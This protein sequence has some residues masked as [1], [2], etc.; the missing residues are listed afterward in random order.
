M[1]SINSTL[2]RFAGFAIGL[3]F[4]CVAAGLQADVDPSWGA[5]RL[6]P[7]HDGRYL[8]VEYVLEYVGERS[9]ENDYTIQVYDLERPLS[10]PRFVPLLD[11][12]PGDVKFS[13]DNSMIAVGNSHGPR[14]YDLVDFEPVLTLSSE[15]G[16]TQVEFSFI[17]FSPDS[18]YI[19]AFS[20]FWEHD[21]YVHVWKIETG[22]QVSRVDADRSQQ[23]IERPWLS[24]DWRQFFQWHGG[25]DRKSIIYEFDP[26]TGLSSAL[27]IIDARGEGQAAFSPDSSLFAMSRPGGEIELYE[28]VSWTLKN[29]ITIGDHSCDEQMSFGFSHSRSLLAITCRTDSRL[30][31]WDYESGEVV[32]EVRTRGSGPR[33]TGDDTRVVVGTRYS[34]IQVWTINESREMTVYPGGHAILH[35]DG[36]LMITIGPDGYVWIWNINLERL[37]LILPMYAG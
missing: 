15:D 12:S 30:A 37:Q 32:F 28:T 18:K 33:F 16:E 1:M 27:A 26:E 7:S 25:P 29:S 20:W 14:V 22:E 31:I 2:A 6:T 10:A 35:P 3:I 9:S 17:Y 5:W 11:D 13:P 24:P 36:E 23:L 19:M 4:V 21:H 34:A 8:A